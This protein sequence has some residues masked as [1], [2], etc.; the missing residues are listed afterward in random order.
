M[1]LLLTGGSGFLGQSIIP[2]LKGEY[3]IKTLGTGDYDNYKLD[4]S[5]E[6]PVLSNTFDIVIHAAGKAHLVPRST[7]ESQEFFNVNLNGTINLCKSLEDRGIPKAFIFISTVS[8]YGIDYG[9]EIK[10]TQLLN[11]IT[12]YAQSKIEAEDYLTGWCKMNNV[13]LAILRPSLIAGKNPPGN[14]GA[15]INGLK[16]G[17]YL[18]IGNGNCRKSILMANDIALL[19]PKLIKNGGIYNVCDSHHPS[20]FEIEELIVKQLNIKSP[21]SIPLWVAKVLAKT[22]DLMGGK[23]LINTSKLEKMTMSLT[24]SNEKAKRELGWEPLDVLQNFVIE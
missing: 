22:G 12:P 20:F 7:T 21:R 24:F 4:L 23:A 8:V 2:A 11:G 15:M 5:K 3:A 1:T 13:K 14:L 6:I 16:T 17:R 19:I 10:E 18:R 9:Y